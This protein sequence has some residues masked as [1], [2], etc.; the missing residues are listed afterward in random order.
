MIDMQEKIEYQKEKINYL[1]SIIKTV[2]NR[3]FLIK[4]ISSVTLS[5]VGF[6]GCAHHNG[7]LVIMTFTSCVPLN[8]SMKP[9][10][11]YVIIKSAWGSSEYESDPTNHLLI[12]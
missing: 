2:V 8:S 9:A 6:T 4:N 11:C 5:A 7:S 10:K 12:S 3:N 1:E